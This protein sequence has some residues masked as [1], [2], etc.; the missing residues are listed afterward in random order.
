M[1]WRHQLSM[2][3]SRDLRARPVEA[4]E[5]AGRDIEV[6]L[7]AVGGQRRAEAVEHLDRQAAGIRCPS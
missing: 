7:R 4:V 1:P 6:E 3:P 2:T 5:G